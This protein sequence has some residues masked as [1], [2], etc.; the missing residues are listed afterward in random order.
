MVE[1]WKTVVDFIITWENPVLQKSCRCLA[2]GNVI[3]IYSVDI[4][5]HYINRIKPQNAPLSQSIRI[6]PLLTDSLR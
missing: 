2:T 4:G 1:W 5:R 6:N 3:R